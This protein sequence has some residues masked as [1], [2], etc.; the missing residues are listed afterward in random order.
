MRVAWC[1]DSPVACEYSREV[2]APSCKPR[3]VSA[4]VL[5]SYLLVH[6]ISVTNYL[7]PKHIVNKQAQV[8]EDYTINLQVSDHNYP[9]S[10]SCALRSISIP[11]I[12]EVPKRMFLG[13][14]E[15]SNLNTKKFVDKVCQVKI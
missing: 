14:D 7:Q 3:V 2:M 13:R 5:K 10:P 9:P 1:D 4:P 12:A 6:F 11:S 15:K 8:S